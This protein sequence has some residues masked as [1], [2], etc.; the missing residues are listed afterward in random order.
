M[1]VYDDASQELLI[2]AEPGAGKST[3]L[4]DLAQRLVERAEQD[5]EVP[6]PVILPLS[7]WAIKQPTLQEWLIEQLIQVYEVPKQVAAHWVQEEQILPLL[8]GLDE[9]EETARPACIAAINTYHQDH[10]VPLVVASRQSEYEVVA[11]H[12]R[13]ALQSAVVATATH[14]RASRRLP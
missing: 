6:L 2:L 5:N 11:E 7:S 3:L 1:Q 14:S 12:E 13:L 4:V 10:L 8:D 9:M